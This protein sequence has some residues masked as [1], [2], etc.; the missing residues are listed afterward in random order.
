MARRTGIVKEFLLF[1]REHKAWWMAPIVFALLALVVLIALG[2]SG[3]A[4]FLYTLF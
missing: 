3:V 1:M 2:S 4:P